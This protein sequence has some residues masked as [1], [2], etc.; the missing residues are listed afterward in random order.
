MIK[1]FL[2][3]ISFSYCL[4]SAQQIVLVVA[5]NFDTSK[6]TLSA[7]DGDK[8][9]LKDIDVNIGKNGLGWGLGVKK[10]THNTNEPLKMEGDKKAPAGIFDI[11]FAFGYQDKLDL[12]IPYIHANDNLLCVDDINS[13]FYNRFVNFDSGIKNFEHMKRKDQQYKYGLVVVHNQQQ[14]K[15]RGSCIFLHIEKEK[16]HPTVGC[17]SMKEKDLLKILKWLD[18][19]KNPILIQVP[20]I[21][22]PEVYKLYPELKKN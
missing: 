11:G 20:K 13:R 5:D 18:K 4:L 21:Y 15:K 8:Q 2:I 16:N 17:T 9:V 1:V 22:L 3:L 6:A 7:Y 14:E 10:I 19:E 12:N